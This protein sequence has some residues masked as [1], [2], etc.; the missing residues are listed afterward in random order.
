[1]RRAVN[2]WIRSAGVFDGVFDFDAT[3]RDPYDP[4]RLR[5]A[6]DSGDNLHPGAT[7]SGAMADAVPLEVFSRL[8]CAPCC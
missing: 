8:S 3:M 6:Y 1:V 5:P 2:R 4:S 7:G